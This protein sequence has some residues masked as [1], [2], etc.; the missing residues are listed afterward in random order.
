MNPRFRDGR[1][2]SG[3]PPEGFPAWPFAAA[4]ICESRRADRIGGH[5]SGW[6]PRSARRVRGSLLRPA[7]PASPANPLPHQQRPVRR[8]VGAHLTSNWTSH[9]SPAVSPIPERMQSLPGAPAPAETARKSDSGNDHGTLRHRHPKHGAASPTLRSVS[10]LA[11]PEE[12][13]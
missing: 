13:A 11:V 12:N 3:Y 9:K 2:S 6:T 8:H 4:S 1:R 5:L 10:G 7:D